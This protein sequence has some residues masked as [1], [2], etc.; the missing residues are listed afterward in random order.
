MSGSGPSG[1]PRI[2]RWLVELFADPREAEAIVGDLVEEF[3]E[4]LKPAR[5]I[6][7]Q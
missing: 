6:C 5:S 7:V 3:H 2:T 1:P 4:T